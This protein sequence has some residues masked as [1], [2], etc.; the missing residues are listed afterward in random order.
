M[1]LTALSKH[2]KVYEDGKKQFLLSM[3]FTFTFSHFADAFIQS[4]L[5]LGIRKQG[6]SKLIKMDK[7]AYIIYINKLFS[8][9]LYIHQI[10]KNIITVYTKILSR[11]IVFKIDNNKKCFLCTKSAYSIR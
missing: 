10:L 6:C 5:Q 2:G 3:L 1:D 7:K 11:A 4:D 9:E 8:L